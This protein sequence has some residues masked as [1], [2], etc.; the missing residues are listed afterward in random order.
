M[1]GVK[2]SGRKVRMAEFEFKFAKTKRAKTKRA[3][4][5]A[6]RKKASR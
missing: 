4:K 6:K 2:F 5:S 1:E 3:K